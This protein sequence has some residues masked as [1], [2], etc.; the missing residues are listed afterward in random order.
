MADFWDNMVTK[1]VTSGFAGDK[2][3]RRFRGFP[4]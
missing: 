2:N 1:I 4:T 3:G